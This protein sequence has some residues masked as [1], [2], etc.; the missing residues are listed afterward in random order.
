MTLACGTI[1]DSITYNKGNC[2]TNKLELIFSDEYSSLCL[3]EMLTDWHII[4]NPSSGSGKGKTSWI[5]VSEQL[6]T[7]GLQFTFDESQYPGNLK[8]LLGTALKSG[9]RKFIS[10][11]GDGTLNA[12]INAVM[13]QNQ[14]NPS[15]IVLAHFPDLDQDPLHSDFDPVEK[16]SLLK[17]K[18]IVFN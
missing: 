5:G 1:Y 18:I 3:T 12:M 7:L 9:K 15:E 13:R 2:S 4:L 14:I 11:G 6:K 17:I 16:H 8:E 10:Y